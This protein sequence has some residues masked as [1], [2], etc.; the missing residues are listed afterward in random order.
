[1]PIDMDEYRQRLTAIF[2][3]SCCVKLISSKG[4]DADDDWAMVDAEDFER[5]NK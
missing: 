3:K 1:M 4:N 2:C 5:G